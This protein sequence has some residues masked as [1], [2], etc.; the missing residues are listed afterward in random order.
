MVVVVAGALAMCGTFGHFQDLRA[1][2][3]ERGED[4]TENRNDAP[5]TL[6]EARGR[7]RILHE[8]LH[9]ALQVMHRD[10]FRD[11]EGLA[12]P[13]RSLEDVFK[14]LADRFDVQLR[15][16]AV[17]ADAMNIDHSPQTDFEREAVEALAAGKQEFETSETNVYR[18]AGSIRLSS[19]CLKCHAPRRTSTEGRV[20]GLVIAIPFKN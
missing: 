16:L 12:I 8:T 5:A 18:Y 10:F 17:N 6:A 1:H 2:A 9:G 3:A 7:A 20:A 4:V 19:Q 11:D 14:E 15:W 13:S